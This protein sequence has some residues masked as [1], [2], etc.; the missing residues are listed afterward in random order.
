VKQEFGTS[1]SWTY[2]WFA[3]VSWLSDKGKT[4]VACTNTYDSAPGGAPRQV[5]Q[6]CEPVALGTSLLSPFGS[7]VGESSGFD[8]FGLALPQVTSVTMESDTGG[9][10]QYA[11]SFIDG[12]GFPCRVFVVGFPAPTNVVNWKLVARD[13]DG[14]Q[15]SVPFPVAST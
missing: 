6:G 10:E 4:L 1:T 13:A 12:R 2:V 8:E 3:D 14:K 7:M 9:H 11:A 15:Q 5:L